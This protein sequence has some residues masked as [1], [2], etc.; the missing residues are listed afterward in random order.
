MTI[1]ISLSSQAEATLKERAARTGQDLGTVASELL[2]QAT[3][4]S[5]QI[6][7]LDPVQA[8]VKQ[9]EE[10]RSLV[11]SLRGHAA[12]LPANHFIDDSR[13]SIYADRGE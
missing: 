6:R 2:E 3:V 13:E 9:A 4:Q 7:S 1:T 12:T 5:T 11:S 10:W 8:R